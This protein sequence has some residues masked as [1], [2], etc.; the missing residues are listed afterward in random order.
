MEI[1]TGHTMNLELHW[2]IYVLTASWLFQLD[3]NT[4]QPLLHKDRTI[5][6]Q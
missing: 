2:L 1:W 4:Q 5:S 3:W 6:L